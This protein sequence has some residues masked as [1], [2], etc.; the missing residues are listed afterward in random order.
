MGLREVGGLNP[1]SPPCKSAPEYDVSSAVNSMSLT[2]KLFCS[3]GGFRMG[4]LKNR[5]CMLSLISH[6]LHR[7][8]ESI[9]ISDSVT[10]NKA[11]LVVV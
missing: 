2:W 9:N 3:I 8:A 6:D 7:Q 5:L 10:N 4:R 1:P 11:S